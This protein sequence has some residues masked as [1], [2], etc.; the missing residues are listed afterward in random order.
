MYLER[1]RTPNQ[2]LR[3]SLV[4]AEDSAPMSA[5]VPP[6]AMNE[7]SEASS[8]EEASKEDSPADP[9]G[10]GK[11]SAEES[12]PGICTCHPESHRAVVLT[13]GLRPAGPVVRTC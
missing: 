3:L 12:A 2:C 10:E 13:S 8:E 4:A 5:D 7:V 9:P 1:D 6:T 11:P